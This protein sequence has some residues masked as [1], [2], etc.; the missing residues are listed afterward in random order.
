MERVAMKEYIDLYQ[1]MREDH[2]KKW[3]SYYYPQNMQEFEEL[4]QRIF[5]NYLEDKNKDPDKAARTKSYIDLLLRD[6]KYFAY[7]IAFCEDDYQKLN[8]A[9]W[10]NGRT[11]LLSGGSTHS[12]GLYTGKIIDGLLTCFACNDYEVIESFVPDTLPM[13][14]V[15]GYTDNVINLLSALYYKNDAKR[16]EALAEAEKFLAKKKLT[17]IEKYYV[18]FFVSLAN[19]DEESV[20][21]CLQNICEAHQRRGYPVKKIEKCFV[22]EAHGFYHLV[23]LFDET[24]FERIKLP[25]HNCFIKGFEEWQKKLPVIHRC[26]SYGRWMV[27]VEKFIDDLSDF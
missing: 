14:K 24:L 12:G 11:S 10:Q 21:E 27:D 8:D 23:R 1:K 18:R 22:P 6:I 17:G 13:L 4:N 15:T 20:N 25:E 26:K 2:Q 19:K 16:Q 9:L 5:K 3:G 7:Y